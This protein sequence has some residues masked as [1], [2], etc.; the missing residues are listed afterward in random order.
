MQLRGIDGRSVGERGA[1]GAGERRGS[2]EGR[3]GV[4]EVRLEFEFRIFC[5]EGTVFTDRLFTQAH[6]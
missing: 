4:E 1:G 5:G 2:E 6:Q 3:R